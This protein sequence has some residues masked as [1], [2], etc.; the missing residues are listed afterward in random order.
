MV[1][2]AASSGWACG[3]VAVERLPPPVVN[4]PEGGTGSGHVLQIP[5]PRS[6][7]LKTLVLPCHHSVGSPLIWQICHIDEYF[8]VFMILTP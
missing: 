8:Q 7:R 2:L 6:E 5:Q 4:S 3:V 1:F